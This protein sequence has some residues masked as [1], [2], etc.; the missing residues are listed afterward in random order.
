MTYAILSLTVLAMLTVVTF[1]ALRK[2][3]LSPLVLTAAPLIALTIIFD[4]FIVEANL[5]AYD[6]SRILGWG[7]PVAPVEDLA[8]AIGAVM[9]IPAVWTWL[10]RRKREGEQ[11]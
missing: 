9:L 1:P 7:V 5:V 3:P 8:Y 10:G 11:P 4:N 6:H 2:L